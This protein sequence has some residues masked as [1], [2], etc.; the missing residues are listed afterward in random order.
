MIKRL[1][2]PL[3]VAVFQVSSVLGQIK[4]D[5]AIFLTCRGVVIDA[6][7]GDALSFASVMVEGTNIAT[8]TNIEGGF[9]LKVPVEFKNGNLVVSFLGFKNKSFRLSDFLDGVNRL[10]LEVSPIKLPDVN[11]VFKDAESL[12]QAVLDRREE[13]YVDVTTNMTAFYR[14]TIK[15]RRTYVSLLESVID[16]YRYPYTSLRNDM[17]A[18][19][20]IR[21]QSD[22][23]KL[24]TLIFKLMGGPYNTMFTDVMRDPERIFTDKVFANYIFSFDKSSMIDNRLVYVLDFKQRPH[25]IEPMFYG[26]L[27]IDAENMA[28]LSAVYDLNLENQEEASQMFIRR[29]PVNAKVK[30]TKARYRVNYILRDDAWYLGYNRIELDVEV[31]W[32]RKLF[33]TV[34]EAVMEMAVT[35]WKPANTEKWSGAESRLKPHVVISDAVFGFA[36]DDFWGPHNVIEPEKPIGNA[37]KKIQKQLENKK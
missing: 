26:K 13:N 33:N 6:V 24:D 20:K 11:V 31:N 34:Y 12:M 4:P 10:E 2:L 29:K 32:K 14:E 30:V 5:T 16:G 21:K 9:T 27:Y 19:Y 17:A 15:K 7:S 18:V 3:F 23:V 25:V 1:F 35:D 22:Y 28:L 37:I 36:D 8:V